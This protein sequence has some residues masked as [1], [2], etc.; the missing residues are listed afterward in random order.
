LRQYAL[1]LTFV[2]GVWT[3]MVDFVEPL[4]HI[5]TRLRSRARALHDNIVEVY[6]ALIERVR[7]R[8]DQGEDVPDCLVKTL[9]LTQEKENVRN[10]GCLVISRSDGRD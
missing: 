10:H 9:I 7:V 3:N 2:E 1:V 4:Q 5:P 8:L 6:G